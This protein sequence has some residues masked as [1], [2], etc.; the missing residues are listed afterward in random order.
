MASY[1][2][3]G[4]EYVFYELNPDVATVANDYFSYLSGSKAKVEI[5][6]G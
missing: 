1:G 5:R 4:D 6:L 3:V 2:H